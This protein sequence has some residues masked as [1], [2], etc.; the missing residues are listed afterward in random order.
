MSRRKKN[1]EAQ[2]KAT[3]IAPASRTTLSSLYPYLA[4]FGL[5]L[6]ACVLAY[7]PAL[8]GGRIWDD[9]AHITKPELRSWTGLYRIWFE[10]GA[11]Q[12]YY[13]L[14]HSAFWL[15]WKLWGDSLYPYHL[16]NV[17]WHALAATLVYAILTK[18]KIP[19]AL[20]A[21]AIFALHPVEVESV[22]WITEQKNTL[23]AVFYLWAMLA[24]LGFDETRNRAEYTLALVLFVLGLLTKTVTATLPAAL[25]VIFWWRRGAISW[26]RDVL[27]LVPFFILG[28]IGGLVTAWVE[29]KLI[30]AEGSEYELSLLDRGLLAGRVIWFYLGKLVWPE[31]LIFIYP[32][33]KVDASVWWQW[34]FS[35]A[36]AV[37]LVALWA[38]HRWWRAPLAGWLFFCGT[39]FPVLGFL[40]VYP[41]RYSFVADH[42]QYLAGL[43]IIVLA[44]AGL[45]LG[46]ARLPRRRQAAG[47]L[48]CAALVGVLALLTW[49]QCEMYS[50]L[51][52]LY[53][54]T[55]ERNPDCW[56]AEVNLG[57]TLV[58]A[59]RPTEAI[60]HFEQALRIKPD[61]ADAHSNLGIQL[62]TMGQME[63]GMR[64]LAEAVRLNP[65]SADAQLDMANALVMSKQPEKAVEYCREAVRLKPN[66]PFAR[67]SLGVA[68]QHTK[69]HEE[70][71]EEFK[72]AVKLY[73]TYAQA[74]EA[75]AR[76]YANL[77]R[78]AEAIAIGQKALTV[79]ETSNQPALVV[80]IETWLENY[81]ARHGDEPDVSPDSI[82]IP[83]P[84]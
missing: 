21:P 8:G 83:A 45:T 7:Q 46:V 70:A 81:R 23:S 3:V 43:G 40:N 20:L 19:G 28:A 13:P 10:M 84:R 41:F 82:T 37:L 18:L 12:Q 50:D 6:L 71:A 30:G 32:H 69:Q 16:L 35:A 61:Y 48:A 5:I 34:L 2:S 73:P 33:W 9:D 27:P 52:T 58:N 80:R 54:T 42:F 56:M 11:T 67:Y 51:I 72:A 76:T 36:T 55:I 62:C 39:L 1:R 29:R 77:D 31:N 59:N 65:E 60:P 44:A 38:M 4:V 22:A 53:Q 79:A 26:R 66:Y 57:V 68:L 17:V 63:Q 78:P 75:L 24:Y 74:Y 25:L 47:N 15:E 49:R 14:L 64:H